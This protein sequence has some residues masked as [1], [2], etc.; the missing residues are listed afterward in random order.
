MTSTVE[1]GQIRGLFHCRSEPSGQK[2]ASSLV[3]FSAWYQ[4][5]PGRWPVWAQLLAWFLYGFLWIPGWWALDLVGSQDAEVQRFGRR[6]L[7]TVGC[8]AIIVLVAITLRERQRD[9][10][11]PPVERRIPPGIASTAHAS[12]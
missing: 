2:N 3:T 1:A 12:P 7:E 10:P 4:Q 9:R 8:I 6:V 11:E 5:H